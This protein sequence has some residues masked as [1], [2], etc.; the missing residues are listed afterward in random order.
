MWEEYVEAPQ[1]VKD[2]ID[3]CLV[4]SKAGK[5]RKEDLKVVYEA[6]CLKWGFKNN[7]NGLFSTLRRMGYHE[8]KNREGDIRVRYFSHIDFVDDIESRVTPS[9]V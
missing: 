1:G 3:E 5:I 2:F 9:Q 6:Y 7:Q 8:T 4:S